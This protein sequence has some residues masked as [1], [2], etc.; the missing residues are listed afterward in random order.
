[1]LRSPDSCCKIITAIALLQ[2]LAQ[3]YMEHIISPRPLNWTLQLHNLFLCLIIE[4]E[5]LKHPGGAAASKTH[6]TAVRFEYAQVYLIRQAFSKLARPFR[7]FY[8]FAP[9]ARQFC[10]L[11]VKRENLH[12]CVKPH[13]A[14]A[15]WCRD[16]VCIIHLIKQLCSTDSSRDSKVPHADLECFRHFLMSIVTQ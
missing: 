10:H 14:V 5:T 1:M 7:R 4:T 15:Y 2:Q 3:L 13:L 6:Y 12:R 9:R 16:V 11:L 8:Q